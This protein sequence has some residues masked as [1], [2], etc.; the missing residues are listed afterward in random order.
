MIEGI[1]EI[2]ERVFDINWDKTAGGG[3]L[4]NV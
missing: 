1:I 3:Q 4:M 2:Q